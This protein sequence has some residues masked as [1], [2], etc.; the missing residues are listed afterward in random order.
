MS[1]LQKP[2]C[3]IDSTCLCSEPSLK[4]LNPTSRETRARP[5]H[6]H[7][8]QHGGCRPGGASWVPLS[9]HQDALWRCKEGGIGD[10][11]Q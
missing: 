6:D 11:A 7:H 3:D 5:A 4:A 2:R 1:G 8:Q 9:Q 10:V